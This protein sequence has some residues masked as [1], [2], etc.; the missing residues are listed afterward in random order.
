MQDGRLKSVSEGNYRRLSIDAF[1]LPAA[2]RLEL[3]PGLFPN[4]RPRFLRKSPML[5]HRYKSGC[6]PAPEQAR[7]TL[8]PASD[9]DF[10]AAQHAGFFSNVQ[11]AGKKGAQADDD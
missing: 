8:R 5:L 6:L 9:K 10:A 1:D 7:R 11:S 4:S 3:G 2:D